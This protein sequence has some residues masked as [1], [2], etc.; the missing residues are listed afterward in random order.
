MGK[1]PEDILTRLSGGGGRALDEALAVEEEEAR[2]DGFEEE[3][4]TGGL[5]WLLDMLISD[6]LCTTPLELP[7]SVKKYSSAH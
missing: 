5:E 7:V 2:R 3:V 6:M 1:V 4:V